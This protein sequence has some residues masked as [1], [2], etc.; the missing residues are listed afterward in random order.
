M[1][2][3]DFDAAPSAGRAGWIE[4]QQALTG[5]SPTFAQP[6]GSIELQEQRLSSQI[7]SSRCDLQYHAHNNGVRF[8]CFFS[9]ARRCT[10][11]CVSS[12]PSTLPIQPL[13]FGTGH[14]LACCACCSSSLAS[15][16]SIFRMAASSWTLEPL[17]AGTGG[18]LASVSRY[19]CLGRGQGKT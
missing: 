9:R 16:W 2:A 18:V 19:C 5:N 6:G 11:F 14:S 13:G 7:V 12:N 1:L 8:R 15:S 10:H 3:L 4:Y 17:S